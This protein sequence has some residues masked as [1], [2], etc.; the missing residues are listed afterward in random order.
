[1]AGG[2][3]QSK[4]FTG[5][6]SQTSVVG[7]ILRAPLGTAMPTTA[8][9]TINA[10]FVGAGYISEEGLELTPDMSTK[11]I[12]EWGGAVVRRLIE[13]F[14][15][16]LAW[17][18]IETNKESLENYFGAANVTV[19]AANATHGEQLKAKLNKAEL[20]HQAWIFQI[21]D[22]PRRITI[23]VGDGQIT[24]REKVSFKNSELVAWGTTLTTFEDANGDH[25]VI[26][27]DDGKITV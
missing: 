3:D 13:T 6:P 22:G 12:K 19:T 21:K 4:I 18:H 1:M 7:A 25:L 8:G 10:A 27:T 24:K 15:S 9:G 20:P 11:D 5:G 2:T 23:C 17:K 14:M 26:L 16:E